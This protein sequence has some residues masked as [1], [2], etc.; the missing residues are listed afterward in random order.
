MTSAASHVTE[1]PGETAPATRHTT[2]EGP[3]RPRRHPWK[4]ALPLLGRPALEVLEFGPLA[5]QGEEV[6]LRL[7]RR[8]GRLGARRVQVGEQL[9]RRNVDLV[10]ALLG[11][12]PVTDRSMARHRG[13][14]PVRS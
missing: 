2:E 4:V 12:G 9:R 8:G 3:G 14:P 13:G 5:L 11:A 6:L 10:G 1:A 7:L